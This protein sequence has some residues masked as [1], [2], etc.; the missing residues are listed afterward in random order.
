M[1][2]FQKRQSRRFRYRLLVA[3]LAGVVLAACSPPDVEQ[4]AASTI[5]STQVVSM[6]T[7]SAAT[8]SPSESST[9]A[10]AESSS[11]NPSLGPPVS[12]PAS[13]S[14]GSVVPWGFVTAQ[15]IRSAA[16]AVAALTVAQKAG[17]V[18]MASSADTLAGQNAVSDLTLGGVILMGDA[19]VIDGTKAGRPDEVAT[20]A[21]S[22]AGQVPAQLAA[23]PLLI[24]VDQESGDV[25]RLRNG[26]TD[27]PGASELGSIGDPAL[28]AQTTREV[29]AVAGAEMAAVG[30][31]VDFAP[32]SDVLPVY[33]SSAIGDRSYG[34]DPERVGELVAAAVLG[35]QSAGIAATLKHFPGIGELTAD[36]HESLP[37]INAS[38]GEWNAVA[39][40]PLRAGVDAGV[41]LL[42]TGH[43][44]FPAVGDISDPTSISPLVLTDLLRGKGT[45]DSLGGCRPL[46]YQ[47]VTISDSLQMVPIADS[48]SSA[49]AAWRALAAGQDLL[50]MP[51]DPAAAAA[52]I[53]AAVAD[54]RLS[55]A[56]L[57]EAAIRVLALRSALGR[58]VRPSMDVIAS[59]AHQ[60]VADNAWNLARF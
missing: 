23:F 2:L 37:T 7:D 26:F 12:T 52:G 4:T 8:S 27:L 17:S 16:T 24:G 55:A 13:V 49:D 51:V 11:A 44:L 43:A 19:G 57:D 36:T 3:S 45:V 48:Y 35:Y 30:I 41:G 39:S 42:M 59:D 33:G 18:I 31:N 10:A 21:A 47:G 50:L 40:V 54:G 34:S 25:T 58:S 20:V 22:V 46:S 32:V 14:T 38:C 28:A 60:A 56:R 53:A 6:N 15:D 29:A 1:S 9:E 5:Q